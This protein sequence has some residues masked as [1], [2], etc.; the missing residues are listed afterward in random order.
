MWRMEK[1][2]VPNLPDL[3]N[4]CIKMSDIIELSVSESKRRHSAIWSTSWETITYLLA[5]LFSF[6]MSLSLPL[7]IHAG[8]PRGPNS[9]WSHGATLST[10]PVCPATTEWNPS[11]VRHAP[12]PSTSRL[13]GIKHSDWAHP[14][15]IHTD[16]HTQWAARK[17]KH[18]RPHSQHS[19][20]E[21]TVYTNLIFLNN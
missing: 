14:D 7:P 15:A 5:L 16:T 4:F 3:S 8:Q 11:W 17:W 1:D 2:E 10:S 19:N 18:P 9:P 13:Y 21:S 20:G 12:Q 6:P